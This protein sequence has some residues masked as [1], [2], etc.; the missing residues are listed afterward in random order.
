MTVKLL[1]EHYLE[2][3]S[4]KVGYTGSSEPHSSK[5]LII[6]Y[7]MSRLKYEVVKIVQV[8]QKDTR[9]KST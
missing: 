3:L 5:C 2:F 4:L 1:T 6:G 9:I 7:H 8:V